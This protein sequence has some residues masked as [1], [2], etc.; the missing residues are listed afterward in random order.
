LLVLALA[1]PNNKRQLRSFLGFVN[2]YQ[3]IWYH[4]SQIISPLT[5]ITSEKAKWIWGPDQKL[6]F[7]EI[8]NTIA[9]QVH[10]KY[11]DFSK[12]FEIYTDALDYQHG[13]VIV[14]DTWP[15]VFY[16]RKLNSAQRNYTTMEKELPSIVETSQQYHHILLGSHGKFFCDR[17]NLGFHHFKSEHVR[18]RRATL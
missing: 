14:Q 10:L 13:A 11:P 18:R 2:F 15:I 12:P 3:Q 9:R 1:E 5:A 16:S 8:R 4:R 7:K 6:A 17:K